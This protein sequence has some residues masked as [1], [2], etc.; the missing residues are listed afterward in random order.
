MLPA[1][2]MR[3]EPGFQTGPRLFFCWMLYTILHPANCQG[4]P[5]DLNTYLDAA[6]AALNTTSDRAVSREI[7]RRLNMP[8]DATNRVAMWRTARAWPSD[9][10]MVAICEIAGMNVPRGLADLSTWRAKGEAKVWWKKI[11][12]EMPTVPCLIFAALVAFH[13]T[14]SEASTVARGHLADQGMY[15]MD[16]K[17]VHNMGGFMRG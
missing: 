17:D 14:P 5:M 15:I 2:G 8:D 1:T 12:D 7:A 16:I 11:A 9:E 3:R 10:A 6:K 13:P 4:C